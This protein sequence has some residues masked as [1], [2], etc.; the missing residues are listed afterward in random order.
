MGNDELQFAGIER[1]LN[2]TEIFGFSEKY[3]SGGKKTGGVNSAYSE[4]P[5]NI[6]EELKK[7]VKDLGEKTYRALGC[8]GIARIDFLIEGLSGRIYVN[9]VNTLPGSLY[10][11]NW[12]KVGVSGTDLVAKLIALAEE[13]FTSGK[14]IIYT[15]NSDVLNKIGAAKIMR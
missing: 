1:S 11:H 5:A 15:F 7:Q 14:K 2:K 3:L 13:R 6:G 8:S 12:K 10:Y 9:E 4:I